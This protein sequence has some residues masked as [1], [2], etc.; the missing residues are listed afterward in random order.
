M[1]K[2]SKISN[3]LEEENSQ[4]E[5]DVLEI[6]SEITL[7]DLANLMDVNAV[8]LIKEFMRN[9]YMLAINDVIEFDVALPVAKSFGYILDLV[10]RE[11][12]IQPGLD[13]LTEENSDTLESIGAQISSVAPG[14]TVD[15]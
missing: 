11:P 3:N 13:S 4:I 12:L 1:E 14:K 9:G 15:S 8:E 5:E 6:P 10:D 7:S 2:D